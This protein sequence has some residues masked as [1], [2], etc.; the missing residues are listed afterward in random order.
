MSNIW[1]SVTGN[2][3]AYVDNPQPTG[4]ETITL[5]AVADAGETL[6]DI[7]ATDYQG[8]AIALATTPVQTFVYQAAW[9]DMYI[10]VVF[11]GVTPPPTPLW[12]WFILFARK[13]KRRKKL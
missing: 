7:T 5:Y 12:M 11:S 3:Y 1:V 2:G 6:D 13:I 9:N 10:N 4:G 8:Y